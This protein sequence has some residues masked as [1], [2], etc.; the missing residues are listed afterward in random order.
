[1][2][3]I[4]PPAVALPDREVSQ[5]EICNLIAP[6]YK[7]ERV[8][9]T[10][11]KI[12]RNAQ[13]E[14]RYFVRDPAEVLLTSD[15]AH[16]TATTFA[17]L[18]ALAARAGRQ[19]LTDSGIEPRDVDCVILT[20]VTGYAMPGLDVYLSAD[21]G[22]RP[23]AALLPVAQVGCAGGAYAMLWAL[24]YL[25][26]H[27][28]HTVLLVSA[29]A[30]SSCLQPGDARGQGAIYFG[31]GGDG[32]AA[33]VVRDGQPGPGAFGLLDGWHHLLP[34]ETTGHYRLRLDEHG[35]HFDS[36]RQGPQAVT[37][38]APHLRLWL[39]QD[40]TE[41]PQFV[42]AHTGAPRILENLTDALRLPLRALHH[43]W[44]SLR[45]IGNVGS[46]SVYH[47][48]AKHAQDPPTPGS[49][50]L[51]FGVGPGVRGVA[52]TA[53][54]GGTTGQCPDAVTR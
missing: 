37:Q 45:S 33:A 19:A 43:S 44:S 54:A 28:G 22:L 30:F 7:D 2:I 50:G 18:R 21:L 53:V 36:S 13:V 15:L 52:L 27:P 23:D 5:E 11:L 6:L 40:E 4:E 3:T 25:R 8:R 38:L 49:R 51:I 14:T 12:V 29:E 24:H 31:L 35:L 34:Q 32:A 10:A 17:A 46:M 16:D 39:G 42:V 1:M 20:S 9:E 47:V 48:L 26:S 41:E